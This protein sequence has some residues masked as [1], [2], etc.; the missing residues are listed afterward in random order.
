[1]PCSYITNHQNPVNMIRHDNDGIDICVWKMLWNVVP[2]RLDNPTRVRQDNVAPGCRSE[3]ELS[4]M[5]AD[6]DEI[7]A[8]LLVVIPVEPE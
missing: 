3:Q 8:G 4:A 6:R 1:M 2:A 7:C 5:R